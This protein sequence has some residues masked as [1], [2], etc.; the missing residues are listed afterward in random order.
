M[1]ITTYIKETRAEMAHVKWPSRKQTIAYTALVIAVSV[2]VAAA[3]G[4]FDYVFSRLLSLF[5]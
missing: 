5:F 3:L 2:A 1:N 4:V